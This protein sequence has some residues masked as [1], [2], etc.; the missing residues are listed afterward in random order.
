[1][2]NGIHSG[3]NNTPVGVVTEA[4]TG[5]PTGELS[6]T[7]DFLFLLKFVLIFYF[8]LILTIQKNKIK[9]FL[10]DKAL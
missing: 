7:R 2:D 10:N 5:A 6:T 4:A 9:F 8:T 1:M 3:E